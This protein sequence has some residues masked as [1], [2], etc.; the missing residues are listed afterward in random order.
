MINAALMRKEGVGKT[1]DGK[2]FR[3]HSDL[4]DLPF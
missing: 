1:E 3:Q 4:E 2:Y